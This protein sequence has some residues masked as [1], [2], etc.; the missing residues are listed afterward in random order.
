M[1]REQRHAASTDGAA[2]NAEVAERKARIRAPRRRMGRA[3]F[4]V[5]K[6]ALLFL[7]L[8]VAAIAIIM[9]VK[10]NLLPGGGEHSVSD[11][12]PDSF[13]GLLPDDEL[14]YNAM[15]F[16]NIVLGET[17]KKSD[18]VVMEQDVVIDTKITQT[19]ANISLFAKTKN[20]HSYGTGVYTVDLSGLMGESI[21]VDM[22][23]HVVTVTIPPAALSYVTVDVKKT[24]FEDTQRG[25]LA[26]TDI[27]MTTE[28]QNLLTAMIEDAMRE[29]LQEASLFTKADESA[30]TTVR[31]LLQPLVSAVS[32]DFVVKIQTE[33]PVG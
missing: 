27:T 21:E 31:A 22:A 10:N 25:L 18:L 5:L 26:F 7:V 20:V 16:Q 15:D 14:G 12:F 8:A 3:W 2:T 23:E 19:L 33:A 30:R 13:S 29:R 4:F 28:Q 24:Q 32:K 9:Y 6:W 1:F 17:R 11:I